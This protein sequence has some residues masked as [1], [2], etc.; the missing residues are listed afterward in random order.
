MKQSTKVKEGG[1]ILFQTVRRSA[2]RGEDFPEGQEPVHIVP[3]NQTTVTTEE[4]AE[5]I[6]QRCT[7]KAPDV[8]A[9]LA[10]FS[11]VLTETLLDGNRLR[12]EGVGSFGLSLK[13]KKLGANGAERLRKMLSDSIRAEDVCVNRV[14][15][16]PS[17]ELQKAMKHAVFANSGVKSA[18]PLA[19]EEVDA[20]LSQHFA[21]HQVL[22]R[23]ELEQHLGISR[24][25]AIHWLKTLVE[26]G[27]LQA[28][29]ARNARFYTP[30][31][32]FGAG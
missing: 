4:L 29:G 1:K 7:V 12:V 16:S 3:Y 28:Q 11:Q 5:I 31:P 19:R 8:R 14:L 13:Q 25:Q 18:E 15:F 26:E 6:A 30:A 22:L 10:A 24:N 32:S 20:F 2:V 21:T 23:R 9:A 27:A 17:R